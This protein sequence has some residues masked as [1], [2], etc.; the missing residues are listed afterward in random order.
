MPLQRHVIQHLLELLFE[1]FLRGR[2]RRFRFGSRSFLIGL[3][4][5]G[6]QALAR[7]QRHSERARDQM[8]FHIRFPLF[9]SRICR[10][11][12]VTPQVLPLVT[13][14]ANTLSPDRFLR[15]DF[16]LNPFA[17]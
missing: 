7:N 10:K 16:R 12:F 11:H 8:K 6:R 13:N 1:F 9:K 15:P 3:R 17:P 2:R 5:I 14:F 4:L